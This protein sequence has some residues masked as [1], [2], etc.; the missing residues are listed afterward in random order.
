VDDAI[1]L[2]YNQ[3]LWNIAN[4]AGHFKIPAVD[5]KRE[6]YKTAIDLSVKQ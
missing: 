6:R 5:V 4:K 1:H 2:S 3:P